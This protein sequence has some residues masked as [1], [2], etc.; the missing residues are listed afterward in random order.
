MHILPH[1]SNPTS[2]LSFAFAISR[3]TI[4]NFDSLKIQIPLKLTL[5]FQREM[6]GLCLYGKMES[7]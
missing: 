2:V 5:C 4:G 6:D 7:D 1:I 3:I